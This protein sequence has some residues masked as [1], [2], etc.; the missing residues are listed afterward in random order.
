MKKKKPKKT[1]VKGKILSK[2]IQG[3]VVLE[4]HQDSFIV[5]F[6]GNKEIVFVEF[7]GLKDAVEKF[8]NI[9]EILS[10]KPNNE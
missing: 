3:R 9:V 10:K 5:T 8:D 6:K 4:Q 2:A 7:R 1:K